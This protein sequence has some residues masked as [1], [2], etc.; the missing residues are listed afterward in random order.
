MGRKVAESRGLYKRGV[1]LRGADRGHD[2]IR[3]I[4]FD[5]G[6]FSRRG[7][8]ARNLAWLERHSRGQ[9][10]VGGRAAA[11]S[12]PSGGAVVDADARAVIGQILTMLRLHGLIET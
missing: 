7:L 11:I 5:M 9:Q 2:R 1:A 8:G 4:F 12:A 6:D 3:P 10:V